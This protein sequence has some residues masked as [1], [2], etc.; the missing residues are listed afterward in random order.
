[1]AKVAAWLVVHLLVLGAGFFLFVSWQLR[2]GLDSLLTGATGERLESIGNSISSDL[3]NARVDEWEGIVEGYFDGYGIETFLR[4]PMDLVPGNEEAEIPMEIVKR[5]RDEKPHREPMPGGR[6]ERGPPM[7]FGE[8]P[9]MHHFNEERNRAAEA[10]FLVKAEEDGGYWA[11]MDV[12][13]ESV[14]REASP[15]VLVFLRADAAAGG[16]LFFDF[17]PWLFGGLAVLALSLLLWAPFVLGVT[18]YA[19][20]ISRATEKIAEGDFAAKIGAKRNDELGRAGD[21]IEEMSGQL[22]NLLSGQKRFLADVAHELC[23]PLAR[24]RTGL[25]I[26]ENRVERKDVERVLSIEE[27]AAELSALVSELLAFTKASSAVLEV[28][29]IELGEFLESFSGKELEGHEVKLEVPEGMVVRADRRLLGR[30]VVNVLRNCHRH[31]GA[32]CAVRIFAKR[33]GEDVLMGIEDDGV[34]VEE[35]ELGRLFEPFY[36]PDRSRTRDTGG[37]GLGMAIV[38]SSVKAFGGKVAASKGDLGG[39]R[40]NFW[41]PG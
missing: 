7:G 3:G 22:G 9:P 20:R 30:A 21:S 12:P 19:G 40:V 13:V 26:L 17:R 34:G 4:M 16:G 11:V 5:L 25:G 37:T 28:E 33:E 8:R 1:M 31:G 15:Q 27:D 18:S 35:G 32:G 2:L 23:A 24:M 10:V 38:E 29:E 14:E 41:L 39:L 6:P 36:R